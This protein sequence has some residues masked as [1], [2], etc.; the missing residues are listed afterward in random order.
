MAGDENG[1]RIS[2]LTE[3]GEEQYEENVG[4]FAQALTKVSR[5]ID[6]H[7]AV[8]TFRETVS[9]D[10]ERTIE[11]LQQ[12]IN[13]Y[14]ELSD[15]Y[16]DY[17]RRTNTLA[18][19]R[20]L[21]AHQLIKEVNSHK[22]ETAL[23]YAKSRL[24]PIQQEIREDLEMVERPGKEGGDVKPNTELKQ[25]YVHEHKTDNETKA[26]SVK[27][28]S[29]A[30]SRLSASS[31]SSS[32]LMRQRAKME[33]ARKRLEYIKQ[34]TS[35]MEQKAQLE[36]NTALEKAKLESEEKELA[37]KRDFAVAEA[38]FQAMEEVMEETE[39]KSDVPDEVT[40]ERTA[41]YVIEQS[42]NNYVNEPPLNQQTYHFDNQQEQHAIP[43]SGQ[44]NSHEHCQFTPEVNHHKHVSFATPTMNSQH[45]YSDHNN[46]EDLSQ[47]SDST[48]S[49]NTIANGPYHDT[50]NNQS[51]GYD[52]LSK[53][54][55][56]KDL[57][58]TRLLKFDDRPEGYLSWKDTFKSVMLEVDANAAEEIDLMI[59][60][61]GPDS[62]RQISSIKISNAGNSEIALTKAWARL[63]QRYGSPEVIESALQRKLQAFPKIAFKDK[64]KLYELSN[65]LSEVRS[66]K[67]RP[68]YSSLLAYFDTSVGVNPTISKLPQGL[69]TKWRDRAISYKRAHGVM[70][71]PFTF[72]CDFISDMATTMNDP[73]FAFEY[74][75]MSAS[76]YRRDERPTK[77]K[78]TVQK[79][80]I[81]QQNHDKVR[82]IIHK[83]DHSLNDCR[84]FRH[85]AIS[86]RRNMLKQHG[87]CFKCCA[88][89]HIFRDCNQQVSCTECKSTDHTTAM[90]IFKNR[91]TNTN[92]YTGHGGEKTSSS[93]VKNVTTSITNTEGNQNVNSKCTQICQN[94]FG[95]KS[96][97]KIVLVNVWHAL[98]D[99]PPVRVYAIIDE[100]SNCSLARKELFDMFDLNTEQEHYSLT[101]CSGK[102]SMSGRRAQ[103]FIVE[104]LDKDH[105]IN[106]P[107]LIECDS[108]PNN[109]HEIP[110]NTVTNAHSHLKCIA[111]MIPPLDEDAE[112]LLLIGRDAL[113]AHHILEQI[114]GQQDQPF[115]QKLMFGWV[116]VGETWLNGT[117]LPKS[118]NAMKTYVQPNGR[119]SILKPCDNAIRVSDKLSSK[120]LF[121]LTPEDNKLGMSV[122]DKKFIDFMTSEMTQDE[123]NSWTAPL[124][125]KESRGRLPNNYQQA[126]NRAKIFDISLHK[127]PVKRQHVLDFMRDII[128]NGNVERAPKLQG[129]E[130]WYLPLFGV[131]HPKKKDRIRVVFDSSAKYQ[132]ISLNDALITG[133]NLVNN[134]V[135]VLMRFRQEKIAVTADIRQMFYSFNVRED[136]RDYLRFLWHE[137]N[138]LD[139]DLVEYRMTVHVFGNSPSPA[140]ATFGLHKTAEK[141]EAMYGSDV[142]AFVEQNFYVDD[143]LYSAATVE[144]AVDLVKRTQLALKSCG[145]LHLHKISSNSSEVL[146]AFD[147]NDLDENLEKCGKKR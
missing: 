138:D 59:K 132:G 25:E 96:C 28:K 90:H 57:V 108:I 112:I 133:P 35:L 74:D 99:K 70:F 41:R 85:M 18:S 116:I 118:V 11:L 88:G 32:I 53:Y 68:E 4:K 1:R 95:G 75:S 143:A 24:R 55:L 45:N 34:E 29:R 130:C 94:A 124:P 49:R 47:T 52:H 33:A 87:I 137:D 97:A 126:L 40:H 61:L 86:E 8:L 111:P 23:Q 98:S 54:L 140:V 65:L 7:I 3:R 79:T 129:E 19:Q 58:V 106:L 92:S 115:A 145:N 5:D 27:S 123:N 44:T 12:T 134:L 6:R 127:D 144:Q 10:L 107:T 69:Q 42:P 78:L 30:S 77:T 120:Y 36:A 89:K 100:Q 64:R 142:K 141:A 22:S 139:K 72:F 26:P 101:S 104:S 91:D 73:G 82:C 146:A 147:T 81:S 9:E 125:F 67:E 48:S 121:E 17:L 39:G 2:Q 38:E 102:V 135:G 114:E 84:A 13:K 50:N 43:H 66:V 119:A 56:K 83:S 76:T 128:E 71:P 62:S 37:V 105:Q 136:H 60:W 21:M 110:T 20:E 93:V 14:I 122:G 109:R 113:T 51:I 46:D 16:K 63:K 117:H 31:S 103:D 80:S 131:Y 15:G